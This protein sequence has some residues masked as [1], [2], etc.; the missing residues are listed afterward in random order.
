MGNPRGF[1]PAQGMST[2]SSA[3]IPESNLY[4]RGYSTTLGYKRNYK[5]LDVP[6]E[7]D[8]FDTRIMF[9]DIQVDGN[10][11]N[12]YKVFQGLSYQDLDRQYGGIIKILP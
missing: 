1:Y 4:N 8:E 12:S 9:S 5:Y 3:K 10:F 7:V 11:K 6:Y 2:K